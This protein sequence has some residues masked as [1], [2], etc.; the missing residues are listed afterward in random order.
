MTVE[1][2]SPEESEVGAD[3][4][5]DSFPAV[6]LG[7]GATWRIDV[8]TESPTEWRIAGWAV[9]AAG[10][11]QRLGFFANGTTG[12]VRRVH[13][14]DV[15]RFFPSRAGSDQAG[16][17]LTVPAEPIGD[18]TPEHPLRLSLSIDGKARDDLDYF[19]PGMAAEPVPPPEN[20]RRVHGSED[21]ASYVLEGFSAFT[22][23]ERALV[24]ACGR[25]YRSFG[26]VLDWGVGCG[27]ISC[28]FEPDRA[29]GERVLIGIDVDETNLAW[30]DEH[31]PWMR[32]ECVSAL[33]PTALE[34]ESVDLVIGVSVF[35][36]LRE[37][38][39]LLWLDELRRI[40]RPG[41]I[42]AVTTHGFSSLPLSGQ[43]ED[44]HA[45]LARD[46]FFDG[47]DNP[48]IDGAVDVDPGYYRN[49]FHTEDYIRSVWARFFTVIR[50]LPA[51]IGN[52][53]DLVILRR[54][55]LD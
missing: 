25:G 28:W 26:T 29:H 21:L 44:V 9:P 32:S 6:P 30:C 24:Q 17:V 55:A 42:L 16:F 12:E 20:R 14:P 2:S 27:R 31:M 54:E 3:D 36:H 13:R 19:Y 41:G 10:P 11:L 8:V 40:T 46:G 15:A 18:I 7:Q 35:T 49:V 5:D 43:P 1:R 34:S 48:D 47:G 23:I 50:I 22:K 37:A 39:M 4:G 52:H 38:D 51:L 53:Q 33:P 45:R